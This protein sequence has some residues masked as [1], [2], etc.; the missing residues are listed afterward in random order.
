MTRMQRMTMATTIPA[1]VLVGRLLLDFGGWTM[2]MLWEVSL[3]ERMGIMFCL[4]F[5][6]NILWER[7]KFERS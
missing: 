6:T 2:V 4:A 1:R 7:E 5:S 3:I